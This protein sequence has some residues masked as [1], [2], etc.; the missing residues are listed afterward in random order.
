V[1]LGVFLVL[2]ASATSNGAN[3]GVTPEQTGGAGVPQPA[4]AASPDRDGSGLRAVQATLGLPVTA[5][6]S[7]EAKRELARRMPLR[8]TTW[9]GPGFYG[10]RTAC[11]QR[12][13]R[14][15]L[16]VAHKR[17]PCGTDVTFYHRGRFLT[18]PVID[19]GPYARGVAFDLTAA[20]A[21]ALGVADTR[22]LRAIH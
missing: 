15:T 18:V 7:A 2:V 11:G 12:L 22:R 9:Y 5:S 13:R 14:A 8:K 21:Q 4:P 16:G 3:G 6:L 17:L 19:R 20:S 1:A 10:R